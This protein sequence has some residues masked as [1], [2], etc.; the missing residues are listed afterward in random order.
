[1][2]KTLKSRGETWFQQGVKLQAIRSLRVIKNIIKQIEKVKVQLNFDKSQIKPPNFQGLVKTTLFYKCCTL[3]SSILVDQ[4]NI[5]RRSNMTFWSHQRLKP[6]SF[7]LETPFYN[8][9][10]LKLNDYVSCLPLIILTS[11]FWSIFIAYSSKCW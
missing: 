1:M 4:E 6:S 9:I 3:S 11:C 8:P 5:F 7:D 2:E 10:T